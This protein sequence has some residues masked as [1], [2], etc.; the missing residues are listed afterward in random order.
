MIDI[1]DIKETNYLKDF[2]WRFTPYSF[3]TIDFGTQGFGTEKSI[4]YYD[5][6]TYNEFEY[7]VA[8]RP[9]QNYDDS[10][11][12][13]PKLIWYGNLAK[14]GDNYVDPNTDEDIIQY[15]T[16]H[17]SVKRKYLKDFLAAEKKPVS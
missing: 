9:F 5:G 1:P 10:A 2:N 6:T 17:I 13:N 16:D 12:L 7:L 8:L 3:G 4:V 11:E 15:K 14:N